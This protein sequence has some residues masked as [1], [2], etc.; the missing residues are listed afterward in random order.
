MGFHETINRGARN[1]GFVK[2]KAP[3]A[4]IIFLEI[5]KALLLQLSVGVK[6]IVAQRNHGLRNSERMR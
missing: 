1:C 4:F 5:Y 6:G 2:G 3:L